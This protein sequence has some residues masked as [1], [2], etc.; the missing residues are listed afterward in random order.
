MKSGY[1]LPLVFLM[2]LVLLVACSEDDP[3][4]PRNK[5]PVAL[6]DVA[7]TRNDMTVEVDI[8]ANDQ[9]PD[10]GIDSTTVVIRTEVAWG[11]AAIDTVTGCL[12]YIPDGN[13]VGIDSLTYTVDDD[14]GATSNVATVAIHVEVPPLP[15]LE[16][17]GSDV[18]AECHGLQHA[19]WVESGH[20]YE[21]TKVEGVSPDTSFPAVSAFFKDPVVPPVGYTWGDISYTIGGY[22]WKMNW[23]DSDGYI[24]TQN[25]DTQ[26]NFENETRIAYNEDDPAGTRKYDC[27]KCHTTGWE[28]SD[29]GDA[30]NN[31]DGLEGMVGTFFTGGVHCEACHG[32]GTRHAYSPG[33]YRM[34]LDR[35]PALC[36]R[37]H[38]RN[39]DDS[40]AVSGGF[41]TNGQQYSEW[42]HSPHSAPGGPGC[43]DCHDPHSSVKFDEIATGSGTTAACTDCHFGF[44]GGANHTSL[45]SCVDCHMPKAVLSAI[46]ADDYVGDVRS[47]IINVTGAA[48]VDTMFNETGDLI[49]LDGNGQAV[50][51]VEFVCIV[52]HSSNKN[53]GSHLSRSQLLERLQGDGGIHPQVR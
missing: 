43:N 49:R 45:A 30:T 21:L 24:I 26:Y 15:P 29:D 34:T 40:I 20:P 4:S 10:G 48:G 23:I 5:P 42:L 22:G 14:E 50:V 25:D 33:E 51:A 13:F 7:E 38:R 32:M 28:D 35:S 53:G 11:T 44:E 27:G 17:A 1:L 37:C 41:I 36:A 18:C 46:T 52:C 39:A 19:N 2:L 9:D 47:H 12:T 16:F 31:Q 8:L 6:D 3:V